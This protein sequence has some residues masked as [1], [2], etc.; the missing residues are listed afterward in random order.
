MPFVEID[1]ADHSTALLALLREAPH[2]R[3]PLF[4]ALGGRHRGKALVDRAPDAT[5]AVLREDLF[6]MTYIGGDIDGPSLRD[7]I[8]ALRRRGLVLLNAEDP[9][10]DLFP[11]DAPGEDPRIEFA[12]WIDDTASL[13][14]FTRGVPEGALVRPI[15]E[16]EYQRCLWRE[17]LLRVFGTAEGYVR[18]SLGFCVVKGDELLS[19]A[20]A[21]YWG[22]GEVEIGTITNEAHRGAGYAT[23][24]C[25]ALVLAC[26]ERGYRT[27][28]TCDLDNPAS[29]AIARK[30]GYKSERPYRLIPFKKTEA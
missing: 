2:D 29:A 5:W 15:G 13:E 6:G 25:G 18:G 24:A 19:E 23:A 22:D 28:W 12:G 14:R 21:V 4:A 7:A 17:P 9:R 30:L 10:R 20:H 1:V 11:E 26:Q 27:L 8:A 16:P 3:A